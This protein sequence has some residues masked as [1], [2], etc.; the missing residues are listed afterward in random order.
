MDNLRGFLGIMR[1]DKVP[2]ARIRE[3]CGGPK[4]VDE[5]ITKVYLQWF[6]HVERRDNKKID[7]RVY[8]GDCA[9]SRSVGWPRKRWNDGMM[10]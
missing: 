8:V 9:V 5:R 2:N 7:K 6:G 1:M 4:G 10:P 3:L